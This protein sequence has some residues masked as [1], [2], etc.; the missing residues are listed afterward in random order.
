LIW[1]SLTIS[2]VK[3]AEGK[4][5]GASKIARD[6]TE[7]K[8]TNDQITTLAREAEHRSKNLL[9]TVQATLNL[10]QSDTSEGLKRAI[11]GRIQALANV[12]SL[13]VDSRWIGAEL[14]TIATREFAPYSQKSKTRVRING[15]QVLLEPSAAQT[16]A[17]IL[18]ELATNAAKYGALSTANGQIDLQW[19]HEAGGRLHLRWTE[20]G[21]P[22]VEIPTRKG[23]GR[24]VIEQMIAQLKGKTCFDWRADGLVCEITLPPLMPTGATQ[25]TSKG[26]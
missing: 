7:Q 26:A 19:S 12:N 21:G 17:V 25:P 10:S 24:R 1:V 9:A 22:A 2:P 23:F 6:I 8:R 5:V 16:I 11:G 3:N 14:S 20:T 15:P 4:I 18:H 13:F